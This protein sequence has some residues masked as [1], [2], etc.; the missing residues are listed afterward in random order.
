MSDSTLQV[1]ASRITIKKPWLLSLFFLFFTSIIFSQSGPVYLAEFRQQGKRGYIDINGKKI[2]E[3]EGVKNGWNFDRG[4]LVVVTDSKR[5]VINNKGEFIVPLKAWDIYDDNIA[6]GYDYDKNEYA[7]FKNNQLIL[8]FKAEKH[9]GFFEGLIGVKRDGKWSFID[10]SGNTIIPPLPYHEVN[11]FING[12]AEIRENDLRGLIDKKG[13]TVVKPG[14]QN[15]AAL[16]ST[17]LIE[18]QSVGGLWGVMDKNGNVLHPPQSIFSF[19]LN[20]GLILFN[21][22]TKYGYLDANGTVVIPFKFDD[23]KTFSEGL[24]VVETN[25]LFGYIDKKG[26]V[27]IEPKFDVAT[28]FNEGVAVVIVDKKVGVIDKTGKYLVEPRIQ[29]SFKKFS[30]GLLGVMENSKWGFIDKTGRQIIPF[31]YEVGDGFSNGLARVKINGKWGYIDKTG[32]QITPF[33]YEGCY[34]FLNGFARVVLNGKWG[35]INRSGAIVV[36]CEY[37]L[38]T[39]FKDSNL[40]FKY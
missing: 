34:N 31:I 20:D 39:D 7:V 37:D 25:S 40:P 22:L 17:P 32:K 2:I 30:E 21:N 12:M 24:A 27:V 9:T 16:K 29:S 18:F 8:N 6:I 38:L 10:L 15:A 4:N 1:T 14:Y 19:S 3:L 23:A 35:F 26:S 33:I 28:D 13:K 5:G 36:P 11:Y